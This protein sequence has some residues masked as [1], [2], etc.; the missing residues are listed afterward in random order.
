[1]HLIVH[2]ETREKNT[3]YYSQGSKEYINK[4]ATHI[5]LKMSDKNR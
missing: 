1:M 5:L 4:R 3:C 2:F